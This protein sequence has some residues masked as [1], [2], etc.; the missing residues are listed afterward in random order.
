LLRLTASIFDFANPYFDGRIYGDEH[1]P[2]GGQIVEFLFKNGIAQ[3]MANVIFLIF[4]LDR[5]ICQRVKLIRI[6]IPQ[7]EPL[8]PVIPNQI[9]VPAGEA[10]QVDMGFPT[11]ATARLADDQSKIAIRDDIGPG[12]WRIGPSNDKFTS[13]FKEIAILVFK[14]TVP[15]CCSVQL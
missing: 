15:S 4:G 11:K 1:R 5:L 6:E 2:L 13:I 12:A 9:L 10:I 8:A 7:V 3:S 14:R